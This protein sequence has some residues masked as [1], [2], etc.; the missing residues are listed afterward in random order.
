MTQVHAKQ[1]MFLR[2]LSNFWSGSAF[3]NPAVAPGDTLRRP[4]APLLS[5]S[6]HPSARP[7]VMS[8]FVSKPLE[9]EGLVCLLPGSCSCVLL[10]LWFRYY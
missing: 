9:G 4:L 6:P 1:V 2:S 3:S 10:L 5:P 8:L 7:W